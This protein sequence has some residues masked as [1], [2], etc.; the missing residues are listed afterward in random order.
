MSKATNPETESSL[1]CGFFNSN[2][3]RRYNAEQMSTIFDGIINDGVFASIG[4]C[5][6]PKAAGGNVISIG[7]GKCWF[8]H[9]WTLNDTKLNITCPDSEVVLNR[10]DALVLRVDNSED[11]RDNFIEIIKGTPATT[12]VAPELTD[13]EYVHYHILAYITRAASSKEIKDA[14]IDIMIGTDTTPFI[15]G[16]MTV[17]SLD[18]LLGKWKDELNTFTTEQKQLISDFYT[19]MTTEFTA[20]FKNIKDQLD[21]DAAGHLQNEIDKILDTSKSGVY[22]I[23]DKSVELPKPAPLHADYLGNYLTE[24]TINKQ[25]ESLAAKLTEL[26]NHV[27]YK[28]P[29]GKDGY[30]KYT[31]V[32]NEAYAGGDPDG[33]VTYE[34]NAKMFIKGDPAW[35]EVFGHYP[36]VFKDGKEVYKLNGDD[37]TKKANGTSA[38]LSGT[39]G[40]VMIAFPKM[41]YRIERMGNNVVISITDN[42]NDSDYKYYAWTK[43]TTVKDKFYF[44]AYKGYND[45]GKLRSISNSKAPTVSQTIGTFRTQANAVGSGYGIQGWHQWIYLQCMYVMKYGN[46]NSQ[47]TIGVGRQSGSA[48][49]AIGGSEKYGM[50]SEIIKKEYA[51]YM[52]DS[53]HHVKCFGIEDLWGNCWSWCD[54]LGLDAN[55]K[56]VVSLKNNDFNDSKTGYTA[57]NA[58]VTDWKNTVPKS[59]QGTTELGFL[60]RLAGGSGST[61][62]CDSTWSAAN[63]VADV[64]GSA[65]AGAAGGVFAVGVDYGASGSNADVGA[66]LMYL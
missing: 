18:T 25:L 15:T 64:G 51:T 3:D 20:W 12:P 26:E 5:F 28:K 47:D 8:D 38:D 29:L 7:T 61:Y 53:A 39:D 57:T 2:G 10:I 55:S 63:A 4:E 14:D 22:V 13:T 45:S 66:R 6:A 46:L 59:V 27:D 21:E 40:D 19:E 17:T 35:D 65:W 54:G 43:G 1:T 48:T 34:D 41:G 23:T 24:D 32:I 30:Y 56:A 44:G 11:V 49:I 36:C 60:A 62:Y 42:P 50:D 52:T 33:M 37:F 31:V 58:I 16:L 9:T